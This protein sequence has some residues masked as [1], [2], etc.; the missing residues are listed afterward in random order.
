MPAYQVTGPDG[1]KYRV[2]TPEGASSQDAIAYVYDTY[3]S[4]APSQPE[5]EPERTLGGYT[6]EAFKGLIPG[7]VGFG[8]T[9]ITGAASLLPEEAEQAVRKPVE[10]FATGVRETFAPA[11]GYEDTLVR[12][13]SEGVGSTVPFLGLGLLGAAGKIGAAGLGVSVGAGEARQKAEEAGATEGQRGVATALGTIPGAL[14]ALPPIRI[15]RRFGFGDE[16]IKEVAGLAP[17]LGRIAKSGG[18][19]ALQEASS[20]VLQNLIAKGVYAP[21]E[22]VFGGVGEAATVGGGAGAVVSAIAELA[23]GRRLRGP[24]DETTTEEAPPPPP[25]PPPAGETAAPPSA[26]GGIPPEAFAAAKEYADKVASEEVKFNL[27]K[28]RKLIRDMG[29]EIGNDSKLADT[30]SLFND[31]LTAKSPDLGMLTTGEFVPET[32]VPSGTDVTTTAGE[33][34][35]EPVGR[36]DEVPPSGV[37]AAEPSI[38]GPAGAGVVP[39]DVSFEEPDVREGAVGAALTPETYTFEDGSSY[40][41]EFNQ[42]T[43]VIDGAGVYTTPAGDVYEGVFKKGKLNGVGTLTYADGSYYKG[44]FKNDKFSGEGE[45]VDADGSVMRGM[46]KAG[47]FLG[48]PET[49]PVAETLTAPDNTPEA[50]DIDTPQTQ[51]VT[52][53]VAGPSLSEDATDEEIA[54][55]IKEKNSLPPSAEMQLQEGDAVRVGG[56][57]GTVVGVEGDYVKFRPVNARR[58]K[59]YQ[60]VPASMVTFEARPSDDIVSASKRIEEQF[61]EEAGV[62]TADMDA[63]IPV[64]GANMYGSNIADVA[65]KEMLQNSFDAVKE[66]VKKG[67]IDV[68]D[69]NVTINENDRTLTVEDDGVGMT[70]D[71]V[72]KAFFTI[73]GSAKE[74]DPGETSGGLG[75][76]KM[77]VLMGA[78]RVQ[79]DTVRDGI[80]TTVDAT[81]DEIAQSNF[82]IRKSPAPKGEHGTKITLKIPQNYIDTIT[83]DAKPIYFP[84]SASSIPIFGKPLVG[85]TKVTFNDLAGNKKEEL[86]IG[87]KFD[88][89]EMP[90]LTSADTAWGTLDIYLGTNRKKH[91]K[92]N[93]LSSG[94]WQF[95]LGF[96]EPAF[97]LSLTEKIPYD[98]VVNVKPKVRAKDPNYPFENSR[99]RFKDR[100]RKDIDALQSYLQR[101]ARGEEA[102]ELQQSF[103]DLVQ[104]PRVEA[105]EDLKETSKKLQKVFDKRRDEAPKQFAVPKTEEKIVISDDGVKDIL[106]KTIVPP[107]TSD[108]E[109]E[110]SFKANKAPPSMEDFKI[111][112]EQD[113]KLP[114]FHNNT[115]VDYVEVGE[116][117]GDPRQFFA[118][119]GTIVVEMKEAL[120]DSG[121]VGW[122]RSYD[123]LKPENFFFGGISI[124]KGYGG[125]H[126]KS[127]PYKAIYLNPFYDWGAQT[128]F[129]IRANI[130]ETITHELAHTGD[131]DHGQRHNQEMIKVR[132]YLADQGLEDY[133]RDAILKVLAKH[134]SVFTA[135]REAYGRSTTTNNAKSLEE[136]NKDSSAASARGDKAGA[137][138]PL[139]AV[140][141]GKGRGRNG[142]VPPPTPSGQPSAVGGGT[143]KPPTVGKQ[144]PTDKR[145]QTPEQAIKTRQDTYKQR[146]GKTSITDRIL[147]YVSGREAGSRRLDKFEAIVKK[148]Q[149]ELRPALRVERDLKRAGELITYGSGMNDAYT[150][151]TNAQDK[152]AWL[153]STM[154]KGPMDRAYKSIEKYAK[155]RGLTTDQA[156]EE[157]DRF[158]IVMHEPERRMIM[159]MRYVPLSTKRRPFRD[160]NGRT[161]QI[162]PAEL[163]DQILK[164]L[165]KPGNDLVSNGQAKQLHKLLKALVS[166]KNNVDPLGA[167]PI[168]KEGKPMS[169]DIND[170]QYNVLG[171]YSPAFI[172]KW[173]DILNSLGTQKTTAEAAIKAIEDVQ[174]VTTELNRMAK[175]WTKPVDNI[176][177]FYDFKHYTPFKGVPGTK[178]RAEAEMTDPNDV[179]ISGEFADADQAMEGRESEADNSVLQS[180]SDA[181]YA[182]SR[183]GRAGVTEAVK[184]LIE[185]G[186]ISGRKVA[187][188]THE[189]RYLDRDFD[190]KKFKGKNKLFHYNDLGNIEVYEIADKDLDFLQSIRRPYQVDNLGVR[191]G[192]NIT[193]F[194]GQMHTRYNPSFAPLN[195]PRDIFTNTLAISADVGGKEAAS[196]LSDALFRNVMK[197]GVFKSGKVSKL[198]NEGKIAEL[199][200]LA[201]TDPFY[202]DV[203]EWMQEGGRTTYQ[204][205]YSMQ[206]QANELEALIGPKGVSP[207]D[208]TKEAIQKWADIYN[209][210]FEFTSRVAA[211]GVMKGNVMARLKQEFRDKNK[212][213]P[214]AQE[215]A[216][217]EQA[218]RTEAASFAKNL[219]N[220]RL[221]G[222]AGREAGALFMFF[223]AGATGAVRAIDAI[224]PALVDE[225][226]ALS[227]APASIRDNPEASKRFLN[228]YK[229]NKRRAQNTILATAAA[230]AFLY[231]LALAGADDDEQGRNSVAT[232]DMARWTR[233]ARL[234]ILG[235]K[236]TFLQIPWGFGISAFG[237]MGAQVAALAAGNES[238]KDFTA[239]IISIAFD[240][241]IPIPKSNINVFDNF[242]GFLV[243]SAAP[244][245]LRPIVEYAMNTDNLG[246]EIYN[247]RQTRY[248]NVFTGG[249]NVPDLYKDMTRNFFDFTNVEV[250]PNSMYFWATN[251]ADA[252]NRVAS[253]TYDLRLFASGQR[254]LRSIDDLD[255]TLVPLDSFLGTRSNYDARQYDDVKN[256][257][258]KKQRI[259]KSMELRPDAYMR[260]IQKNPMDAEIVDYYNRAINGELKLLQQ[261]AKYIRMASQFSQQERRDLL[262]QNTRMQNLAKRNLIDTFKIYGIEPET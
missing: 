145:G 229:E 150:K 92:H 112:M 247:N 218:A 82:K 85:P 88:T 80:R 230:G 93:V 34:V 95:E 125:I 179:R 20:Q 223:R 109:R 168:K 245:A 210:A 32:E 129:G 174:N 253:A 199:E 87:V 258:E 91:P 37:G 12:K 153:T 102:K 200:K 240:S 59:A 57:P 139:R 123:V 134:E 51:S 221:I 60:R 227:K 182:A 259:L 257:I 215:T 165:V 151:I 239:N 16:A 216:Q 62:F 207:Y 178:V 21:D 94:I 56:M 256:Q 30:K 251:Y 164:S 217:I 180:L 1:K 107:K 110:Q 79:I 209:D 159:F 77:G 184:N 208:K 76:A 173:A 23:L 9:A 261:D 39:A 78:E 65:V 121:V 63:L 143:K 17:A 47:K 116:P 254:E 202:N 35:T 188:V 176:V 38:A 84:W 149:N 195:F 75:M 146:Y 27:F 156:I 108:V 144:G 43:G 224:M 250:S 61:G 160:S 86:P 135:M 181:F 244:S 29:Y 242:T 22:A 206:A 203:I 232:D 211:Y 106:G 70:P 97:M 189:Q 237:A 170:E 186:H 26:P 113:P 66:S 4:Q 128:L 28:A 183:A 185:Q 18:E 138:G 44:N 105:G 137:K 142:A 122:P 213:S 148:F 124:D 119:L 236:D 58:E 24:E 104:M 114:V 214:N 74:L 127:V 49:V 187:E 154:L 177:A 103:K 234:P 131:M 212:R 36:G 152:A 41:G 222:T 190:F 136:Y 197:G 101:I 52:T 115:N 7:L 67:Q 163:R 68:G 100:V 233:Y 42:Q 198:L 11:P 162:S 196:Y 2:N 252:L 169:T 13:I 228:N 45:F 48:E 73:G 175:Y 117:Y 158:R 249:S 235:G 126:L 141:T 260:Y 166:D 246:N 3:Y 220:F 157:L 15:L 96:K 133:F 262:K 50:A 69:I 130:Y 243:D 31:I 132:Q 25:P 191:W 111:V 161:I 89:K 8:E 55:Y 46:F 241:F 225:K 147:K 140:S 231:S 171:G 83:G 219:A 72:R 64:I 172:A 99:E 54:R 167:S 5:P 71:I 226:T 53:Q 192:N 81:R 33:T 118:E 248:S 204:Q 40:S 201:K 90:K 238:F 10:E 14:E 98:I 155:S 194:F 193:G 6:K 205:V 255:R 19:E 120:G